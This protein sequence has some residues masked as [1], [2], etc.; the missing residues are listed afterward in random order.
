MTIADLSVTITD[1]VT[2]VAPGDS[3]RYFI[4]VTNN[5][6]DTVDALVT[7]LFP[8]DFTNVSWVVAPLPGGF[9]SATPASGSGDI[10][11]ATAEL[12]PGGGA[13]FVASGQISASPTGPIANTVTVATPAGTTDYP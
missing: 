3:T 8:A 11:N 2:S 12:Q 9:I 7:D 1:R 4:T 10:I 6:P 5:G 13:L